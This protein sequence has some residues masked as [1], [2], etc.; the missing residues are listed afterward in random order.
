MR[1]PIDRRR[2]RRLGPTTADSDPSARTTVTVPG[3]TRA[4]APLSGVLLVALTVMLAS[5]AAGAVFAAADVTDDPPPRASLSLAVEDRTLTFTHRGGDALDVRR[6]RLVVTVDGDPLAHQPPVPFFAARGFRSGPVG[7]FNSATGG[8]WRAGQLA[9]LRLA[10][11]NTE[12]TSGDR[13]VV[14][15][16]RDDRRLAA[17]EV[18]AC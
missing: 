16:Y 13:V 11:T 10:G 8:D 14:R 5:V 6:L 3:S 4:L 7:P 17:L 12:I 15:I 9:A 2:R 18:T 1:S